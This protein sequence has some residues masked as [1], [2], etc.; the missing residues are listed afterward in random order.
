MSPSSAIVAGPGRDLPRSEGRELVEGAPGDAER[1]ETRN[2]PAMVKN[3]NRHKRAVMPGRLEERARGVLL[4]YR[5][6]GGGDVVATGTA[7]PG[8]V[9]VLDH[10]AVRG[11]IERQP[12]VGPASDH[13]PRTM[14]IHH[15]GATEEQVGVQTPAGERPL[16]VQ[17]EPVSP[18]GVSR[19]WGA[20]TPA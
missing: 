19:P 8:D 14:A 4:R 7:Q 20:N 5:Q 2:M 17:Q 18:T 10:L 13:H 3:G 12:P 6:R 11:R 1:A 9:P 15:D 16:A